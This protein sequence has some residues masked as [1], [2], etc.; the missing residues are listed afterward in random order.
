MDS[1]S[2]LWSTKLW[3]HRIPEHD[4]LQKWTF[5]DDHDVHTVQ[6]AHMLDVLL[7]VL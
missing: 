5:V 3:E 1:L 7:L 6:A 4:E 2:A